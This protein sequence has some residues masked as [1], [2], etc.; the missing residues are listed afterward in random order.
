MIWPHHYLPDPSLIILYPD[1]STL[2]TLPFLLCSKH[3]RHSPSSEPLHL[4]FPL[5]G[6]LFSKRPTWLLS[7]LLSIFAQYHIVNEANADHH[8][9]NCSQTFST[10]ISNPPILPGFPYHFPTHNTSYQCIFVLSV[11]STRIP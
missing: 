7:Q 3:V 4:L 1:H 9:C 2:A 11:F 10:G 8:I 6:T 5:S